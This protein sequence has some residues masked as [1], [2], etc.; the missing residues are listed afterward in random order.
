MAI[1]SLNRE[2]S[3]GS[4]WGNMNTSKIAAYGAVPVVQRAFVASVHNTTA[5]ATSSDFGATQLAVVQEIQNTMR[6][7]GFWATI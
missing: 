2:S 5:I 6:N 3:E 7:L 4:Q 1:E